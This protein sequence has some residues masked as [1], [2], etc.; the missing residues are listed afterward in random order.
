M[1]GE[2]SAEVAGYWQ[3]LETRL[4][5]TGDG[6]TPLKG[7]TCRGIQPSDWTDGVDAE[8]LSRNVMV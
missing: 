4:G 1:I 6:R 3:R 2:E 8:W 7:E 5:K